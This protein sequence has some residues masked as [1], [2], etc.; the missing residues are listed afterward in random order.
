MV[1][2]RGLLAKDLDFAIGSRIG[3]TQT[4]KPPQYVT[5]ILLGTGLL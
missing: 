2:A 3:W 5:Q 4:A 1:W